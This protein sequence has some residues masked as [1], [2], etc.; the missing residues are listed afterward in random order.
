MLRSGF[1]INRTDY[2]DVFACEVWVCVYLGACQLRSKSY[3]LRKRKGP[4]SSTST[5]A[6]S[7]VLD[8][9]WRIGDDKTYPFRHKHSN[10]FPP[11]PRYSKQRSISPYFKEDHHQPALMLLGDV[12]EEDP[13]VF[14]SPIIN[15]VHGNPTPL[16][17][18]S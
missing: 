10:H 7:C 13:I 8:K 14:Q 4:D 6:V 11:P 9:M 2:N 17:H 18:H 12:E 16:H 5:E 1:C 3:A 15:M